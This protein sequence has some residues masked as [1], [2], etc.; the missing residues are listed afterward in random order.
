MCYVY[1]FQFQI[2]F[3]LGYY[4]I[5]VYN[6]YVCLIL[7]YYSVYSPVSPDAHTNPIY[8][9]QMHPVND[10]IKKPKESV[11]H[12]TSASGQEYAVPLKAISNKSEKQQQQIPLVEYAEADNNQNKSTQQHNLT[13]AYDEVNDKNKV[14][15]E[16]HDKSAYIASVANSILCT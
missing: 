4:C 1:I 8:D 6:N 15:A 2:T 9:L 10:D 5:Y 11:P 3:I 7:F 12:Q 14:S 13:S 16:V